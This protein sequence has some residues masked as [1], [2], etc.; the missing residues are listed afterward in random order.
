VEAALSCGER[1]LLSIWHTCIR[2]YGAPL[3]FGVGPVGRSVRDTEVVHE[4][5]C[6]EIF[7]GQVMERSWDDWIARLAAHF[8]AAAVRHSLVGSRAPLRGLCD[9]ATHINARDRD[10]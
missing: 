9:V 1:P 5:S 8:S 4:Y 7:Q 10:L 3:G 2:P 6:T